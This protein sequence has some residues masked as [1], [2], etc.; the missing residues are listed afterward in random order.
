[1]K[2]AGLYIHFPFC[3]KKC[4]YCDF[5]S[6][7]VSDCCREHSRCC[8]NMPLRRPISGA[9]DHFEA[10]DEMFSFYIKC[11]QNELIFRLPLLQDTMITSIF[12]GG[13]TPSLMSGAIIRSLMSF[14]NEHL[15]I[16][17]NAEITMECNPGTLTLEKLEAM[18][19]SGI[20]R[21]SIGLQSAQNNE[22]SYLGRIHT[23]ESFLEN[24]KNA[25]RAGFDN[26]NI[27]LM[28][29]LPGQT[30]TSYKQTLKKI[31][32][33]QPEHISAYSL[34]I[35]EGTRFWDLYGEDK[36][37][38]QNSTHSYD[39]SAIIG[40]PG[41]DEEREMYYLTQQLLHEHGYERYELSNYAKPGYECRHNQIYWTLTDYL[42]I[43]LGSSSLINHTRFTNITDLNQYFSL[44]HTC[45]DQQPDAGILSSEI[46]TVQSEMEEFMFLG[47]RL[48]EGIAPDDFEE[49][50]GCPLD[51]V[52]GDI[53]RKHID[54]KTLI[55]DKNRLK[56][57]AY[58]QDVAN[59][60]MSDFII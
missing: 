43:G 37:F 27:D 1:M 45:T 8:E 41:E 4:N 34:I 47:L 56:L 42:G 50:F 32:E 16:A 25:R 20:N 19:R 13:G 6:F 24:Y 54:D 30:I 57:T 18:K 60:V 10:A 12:F 7:P 46:L 9:V 53:I 29:A 21:I 58:G 14:L 28:S 23:F 15:S 59:Y 22:L 11:V 52:Y 36:H 49:R 44:W 33:L 17:P 35:E 48:T 39:E 51:F 38:S 40:L 26:I 3:V 55:F 2:T 31:L 5:L